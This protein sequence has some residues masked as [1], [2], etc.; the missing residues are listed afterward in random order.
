M[1]IDLL[2]NDVYTMTS[3]YLAPHSKNEIIE[4]Y[5]NND[6]DEYKFGNA[7]ELF[8]DDMSNILIDE[9]GDFFAFCTT[10]RYLPSIITKCGD[11]FCYQCKNI[12]DISSVPLTD[13][14]DYFCIKSSVTKLP[15]TIVSCGDYFCYQC[16]NICI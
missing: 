6:F 9:V 16:K 5:T 1:K 15:S 3:V 2:G 14:G 8:I 13:V 11:N 10:V 12:S 7:H 4:I